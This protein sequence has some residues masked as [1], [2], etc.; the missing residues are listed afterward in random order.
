MSQQL[1]PSS[2][3]PLVTSVFAGGC[4]GISELLIMYPLDVIKTRYQASTGQPTG[5]L[6]PAL[7][8]ALKHDGFGIYRGILFPIL[9][10]APKRAVKFTANSAFSELIKKYNIAED[11]LAAVLSGAGTGMCEGL[12][13]VA[14]ELIKIRMQLPENKSLYSSSINAAQSIIRNEGV[15]ALFVGTSASLLRNGSWNTC[16]FGSISYI[17]RALGAPRSS[18]EKIRNDL[19]AGTIAGTLGTVCNTPFDVIKTRIQNASARPSSSLIPTRVFPLAAH[20]VRTEGLRSLW[21]G[22][23]PK[24]VRLGPGGGIMLFV[25]DQ[26]STWLSKF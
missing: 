12:L 6:V 8:S 17:R 25:Y 10:E 3:S 13:V 9:T 23:V 26:V 1:Q 15:S 7:V 14:P 4:A 18:Q 21:K 2:L 22:F 16:Y 5:R 11:T 20:I 24:V 19:I